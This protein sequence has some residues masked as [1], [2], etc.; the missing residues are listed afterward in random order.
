[1]SFLVRTRLLTRNFARRAAK[2]DVIS[3]VIPASKQGEFN[4]TVAAFNKRKDKAASVQE[5][6]SIDFDSYVEVLGADEV[7]RIK[8]E[9]DAHEY[10]DFEVE[11]AAELKELQSTLA[12]TVAAIEE[13]S[14]NLGAAAAAASEELHELERTRTT[15][16]TSIE[17]T[18]RQHPDIVANLSERLANEDWDTE[19]KPI[20]IN[21]LRLETIEKNW[22]S[23]TLG[24]L[25]EDTQ[26]AF[27]EEINALEAGASSA[28]DDVPESLQQYIS[29]WHELLG[30]QQDSASLEAFAAANRVTDADL[31]LT[32]EREIWQAIDAATELCMFERA[33][34]LVEHAKSVAEAGNLVID[35]EWRQTE[36]KKLTTARHHQDY[37]SP[38]PAEELEG[39][40]AE[41]LE[42]L[43]DAA[44]DNSDFYKA[45]H[46]LYAARVQS[47][48]VDPN[49][50]DLSNLS[51]FANHFHKVSMNMAQ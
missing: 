43:A 28:S 1:M 33:R 36:T 9:Y 47:G 17:D 31:Q 7:N 46:Y 27:L 50:S 40:T 14:A 25:D 44:A 42:A 49:D 21:A 37:N 48:D 30:R 29:D 12:T 32:N 22:D 51:G 15:L 5:N 8:A 38:V 19:A 39:R 4:A 41:E 2:W 6:A 45:A 10:T 11:K 18:M 16:E 24:T 23:S 13:Q 26:K 20:D 3:R 34:G 35:E